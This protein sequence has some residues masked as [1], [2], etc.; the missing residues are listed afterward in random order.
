M[1]RSPIHVNRDLDSRSAERLAG[2]PRL[3][4]LDVSESASLEAR[5]RLQDPTSRSGGNLH[6]GRFT[7]SAQD[8]MQ[9]DHQEFVSSFLKDV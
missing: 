5:L 8:G 1:C 3:Q 9:I 6:P 2:A 7:G 4:I